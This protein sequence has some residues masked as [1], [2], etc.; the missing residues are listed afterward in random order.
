MV[1]GYRMTEFEF[2]RTVSGCEAPA[3]EAV[4]W[5]FL[6]VEPAMDRADDSGK[7]LELLSVADQ[8]A[9]KV[10]KLYPPLRIL[11]WIL[12]AVLAAC[13]AWGL[14]KWRDEA[15]ITY[16]TIGILLLVLIAS[17][18]V[19]KGVM[20]IAR[21]RETVRKILFGIGMALIGF[22]AAKIHLAFF[23]KLFLKL[24][25]IERLLP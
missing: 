3:E 25:R 8:G 14:W 24:G 16:Q 7:L 21:F 11:G 1:S 4:Q 13:A 17:A 18:V 12:I 2:P 9:F 15:V 6:A 19:G 22:S 23:D 5:P 20:R 10:W